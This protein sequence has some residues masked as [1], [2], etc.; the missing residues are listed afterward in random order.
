MMEKSKQPF[1]FFDTG[2][3]GTYVLE[4]LNM[5]TS[6]EY[7]YQN[8]DILLKVDQ[9]GPVS[10]QAYPPEDIMVFKREK[11]DRYS[12]WLVWLQCESL[13][14]GQPFTNFY[15]PVTE[16]SPDREPENLKIIFYPHKAVYSFSMGQLFIETV[17]FVPRHGSEIIM[18]FSLKN[19]GKMSSI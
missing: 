5:K 2:H 3:P 8:R 6:W 17:F 19:Q 15:R 16:G 13:N 14:H 12:K 10:A 9:Y 1:G 18:R 11:D 7:I 4:S